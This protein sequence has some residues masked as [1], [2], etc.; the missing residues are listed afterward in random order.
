[1]NTHKRLFFCRQMTTVSVVRHQQS[2]FS[3][4]ELMIAMTLGLLI[5]AALVTLFINISR[6]NT[7]M[8][9]MNSQIENGRF[10]MQILQHDVAHAGFWGDFVPQFNDLTWV[11]DPSDVPTVVP[12]PCLPHASWTNAYISNLVGIPLQT[13]GD[14]V[15]AGAGCVT[16]LAANKKAGTD[17]LVVRH[18]DTCIP[19]AANCEADIAGQLY[20]QA[21]QCESSPQEPN[22]LTTIKLSDSASS[23]SDYYNGFQINIVWGI[24][25]GQ[26]RMITDYDGATRVATVEPAWETGKA[27]KISSVYAFNY[28]LNTD[29]HIFFKR[30]CITPADKRKFVSNIYYVRDYANIAGDGIPTLMRSEFDLAGGVLAHQAAVPLIEGIEGFVVELGIDSI[31]DGGVDTINDPAPN[32]YIDAVNW[33]DSYNLVSPLNRG[34]GVPDYYVRC[35]SATPCTAAALA[36]VVSARI[37]LLARS[38]SPTLG[39]TDSKTYNLGDTVL[40]PFNDGYKRH[41]FSTT[42]RL[43]N[44]SGRRETP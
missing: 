13:Y 15:P 20:F 9:K 8:A 32:R 11:S 36:N 2:G 28:A 31:S 19:G 30:D 12:D 16:N 29:R 43:N 24:G 23:V 42:V 7:E 37:H 14:S 22:S 3:M 44:V 39:Y 1:M 27:P 6:T 33:S 25:I 34:D 4:V 26:S 41:V 10:S 40:G 18:A 35:S 38:D 17:I 21:A 5:L